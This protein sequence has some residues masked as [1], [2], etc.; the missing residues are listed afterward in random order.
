MAACDEEEK[1][2]VVAVRPR[3]CSPDEPADPSLRLD[4]EPDVVQLLGE[5]GVSA[6]PFDRVFASEASNAEVY[7]AVALPLVTAALKGINAAVAAYGQTGSGKTRTMRG[8]AEDAG[9]V[10]RAVRP[11]TAARPF[12]WSARSPLRSPC[13]RPGGPRFATSTRTWPPPPPASSAWASST[14]RFTT[15]R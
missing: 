4:A 6:L 14:S 3:P 1:R 8:T 11:A 5:K 2:L 10:Q 7:E 15:S 12:A 9:V 13:L